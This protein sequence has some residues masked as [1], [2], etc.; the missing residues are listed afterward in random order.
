M[1]WY[2]SP[3]T[4]LFYQLP[5]ESEAVHYASSFDIDANSEYIV[6]MAELVMD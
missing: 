2:L 5:N 3:I 1:Y 4:G 6:F